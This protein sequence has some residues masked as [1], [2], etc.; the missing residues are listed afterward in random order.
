MLAVKNLVKI[1]KGKDGIDV[2]ALDGVSIDFPEKGMVF[3]LGKSGSGKSTLLNLAGGLD[4]PTEGEIIVDGRSSKDFTVSD[5]DGYRNSCVGFV[6][7]EFNILNE[8]TIEQNIALALQLQ[9][10]PNNAEVVEELLKLVDLGGVGKRK[11][12]TLSGGQKQRV[13]I[14]R[15]LIKEPKIIM[16]DEPTGALDSV[17]GKQVLDT[18]KK[19]SETR[20][21]VVVTHD[22]EFAEEYGDRIIELADGKIISDLSRS[23]N[24]DEETFKEN[25]IILGEN[26]IKVRDWSAVTED[27]VR[28]I[29]TMMKDKGCSTYITADK[30][31]TDGIK[32]KHSDSDLT[33]L[34]KFKATK[35]GEVVE[36]GKGDVKFIKSNLPIKNA[37]KMAWDSIKIKPIRL[38]FTI[39]LSVIAFLFFGVASSFMMYSPDYSIIRALENSNYKQIVIEKKYN[40]YYVNEEFDVET[41]EKVDKIINTQLDGAF[42]DE[43]LARLNQNKEGLKF[44]GIIDFGAYS[45]NLDSVY[46]YTAKSEKFLISGLTYQNSLL[47]YYP[48]RGLVGFTDCGEEYLKECGYTFTEGSRYPEAPNEIMIS[49]Y[50][51]N[52]IRNNDFFYAGQEFDVQNI[53][54]LLGKDITFNGGGSRYVLTVTGVCRFGQYEEVTVVNEEGK[55]ENIIEYNITPKKFHELYNQETQLNSAQLQIL[56]KQFVDYLSSSFHL[57]GMVSEDF[58]D[59]YRE[60]NLTDHKVY[61]RTTYGIEL[62]P[63]YLNNV[64]PHFPSTNFTKKSVWKNDYMINAIDLEGNE[65]D[66]EI[67]KHQVL[68]PIGYIFYEYKDGYAVDE[69]GDGKIDTNKVNGVRDKIVVETKNNFTKIFD[70][71]MNMDTTGFTEQ[72]LANYNRMRNSSLRI[73]KGE[74]QLTD[75]LCLIE[76][77][78]GEYKEELLSMIEVPETIYMRSYYYDVSLKEASDRSDYE[79]TNFP[80]EVVGFYYVNQGRNHDAVNKYFISDELCEEYGMNYYDKSSSEYNTIVYHTDYNHDT[81]N[82]K[83]GRIIT[84]T[85]N[86]GSQTAFILGGGGENYVLAMDNA[87][88]RSAYEVAGTIYSLKPAFYIAGAIF[89]VFSILMLFNFISVTV[90]SKKREI[91]ILR[92]VGARRIDVFKIFIVE[93]FIITISCFVISSVLSFIAC[94]VINRFTSNNVFGLSALDFNLINIALLLV[95]SIAVAFVATIL[96]VRKASKKAPVDSIRSI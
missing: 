2:H 40:A 50:F 94:S 59:Y 86:K 31:F 82:E 45:N 12:N 15:A 27:D 11:P 71:V 91:G 58:Y 79:K 43:D 5:F 56:E 51:F 37:L 3:L 7:Q 66:L 81:L 23:E 55:S 34:K 85:L 28:Q 21:V 68:L 64:Y 13:A 83:Y 41:G 63:Y 75:K 65:R 84:P 48:V 4:F 42:S 10:K 72:Q 32:E 57:L 96:P 53:N 16:A 60:N 8:F 1:Y 77:L 52:M 69:N 9:Q 30:Q 36:T 62:A 95:V 87:I 46:G 89:G 88:Y 20:L 92:A 38:T 22:R 29:A 67:E 14:A 44:A 76:I 33:S 18:L 25:V 70:F 26:T 6:F 90:T 93:A 24:Q 19:L 49:D 17:T 73:K 61:D 80:L 78:F 47:R 54:D 35:K 74:G 39:L